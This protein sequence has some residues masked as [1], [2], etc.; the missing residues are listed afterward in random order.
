MNDELQDRNEKMAIRMKR[1]IF[2]LVAMFSGL[3]GWT[4]AIGQLETA[5]NPAESA[6]RFDIDCFPQP[7]RSVDWT[8]AWKSGDV[9]LG[10]KLFQLRCAACHVTDEV[11]P[12][13]QPSV[14]PSLAGVADRLAPE[15][16]AQSIVVPSQNIDAGYQPWKVLTVDGNVVIGHL[17]KDPNADPSSTTL[18]TMNGQRA[19]FAADDIEQFVKSDLSVMPVGLATGPDDVKH[20]TAFLMMLSAQPGAAER[21][22]KL[23]QRWAANDAAER[24]RLIAEGSFAT[25]EFDSGRPQPVPQGSLSLGSGLAMRRGYFRGVPLGEMEGW[26]ISVWFQPHSKIKGDLFGLVLGAAD[27]QAVRV[28]YESGR[29]S[30]S[31][32]GRG[33]NP[34][35]WTLD[36]GNVAVDKWHQLVITR[37]QAAGM[38][39][40]VDGKLSVEHR[41]DQLGYGQSFNQYHFGAAVL[42]QQKDE[43]GQ[44]K[45]QLGDF[46]DGLIDDFTMYDRPLSGDEVS[47]LHDGE[48]IPESMVA[49]NDFE[50]VSHRDLARFVPSADSDADLEEGRQLYEMNCIQCH[51]PDGIQPPKNP[52]ARIFTKHKMENGGDPYSMF[53]TITYGF[54]NMMAAPQLSPEERYKVIHFIREKMIRQQS[55]ELYVEIPETYTNA[56]PHNPRG[57]GAAAARV[58]A[59]AKSGYLRDYGRALIAPVQGTAQNGIRSVNALVVDLGNETTIAYDLGTMKSLGAWQG[60]FL[61]FSNTLHHKLRAAG[62][63]LARF[64]SLPGN[65]DWRWA[66]DGD[67]DTTPP[68]LRPL[69][70]WPE[71][72]VRYRGH[73]PDGDQIIVSYAVQGRGVLESPILENPAL[74]NTQTVHPVIVR[75]MTIQ[76]AANALELVVA[77]G[78]NAKAVIA[79]DQATVTMDP[80]KRPKDS[81]S[82]FF[83]TLQTPSNEASERPHWRISNDGALVLHVPPS[84]ALLNFNLVT[85]GTPKQ[86]DPNTSVTQPADMVDLT[87]RTTGGTRRWGQ[88][89]TMKGKLATDQ[90]QGYVM[91]SVP[92]PL[93]NAYN[94]WMRTASLAFFPDGRLAVATLS[95]D[96]WIV[97]GLD[98]GLKAVTWQRFAA[99]LYEPL[100]MKVVDDVLTVGTRG[101]IVKLH[102]FNND[103]EADF[104]E[105]FFN[106]PEPDPGWHA[107]SFDL[108]VGD[109]GSYYYA[110]VGGFSDWSVPGG[111]VRVAADGKS[112]EVV[113]AGLRVPN[114]IGRLPDGRITFGDNQGTYVPASKIAITHP[115]AFHGA[116]KWPDREGDYD[117]E[118]IVAPIVY[119]PQ[120]LDSS[121]GSQLWV[122]P[123]AR[124]GPL[125]GQFFHT[126]YGR[127]STMVV[128]L[129]EADGITQGAVYPIP[130]KM[131]SGTMRLAKDPADGQLYFSG[132]TGWQAG[133]TREGSIQRMRYT[134][135]D[136]LYLLAAKAR[137]GR[138]ELTFN[139]PLDP[140]LTDFSQWTVQAWNYKWSAQYGSP[141]FKV[142]EPGVEGM[143]VWEIDDVQLSGDGIKAVIKVPDLQPCDTL[144]LDFTVNAKDATSLSSPLYFTIHN[145]PK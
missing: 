89:H 116:G 111:I 123:D 17:I 128:L 80:H 117:P 94:T 145:L 63:P 132:L 61:D 82:A 124:F 57:S 143:D 100:G 129:D 125:G 131:E 106:E 30:V 36:A 27:N 91:D 59:L 144:K 49:F 54:R 6:K 3:G 16:M 104:Y 44:S 28:T 66:W 71:S 120:E 31:G 102:D 115:G 62:Q 118:K 107:Y 98:D 86:A 135:G 2:G 9:R 96:V 25:P 41:R 77:A 35:R 56:M 5:M 37:S 127:A 73:Y 134:G 108:E 90:F 95:G 139:Q 105:A 93:K 7:Y 119:M 24:E 138:L 64:D 32:P 110:R 101:R 141:H 58:E 8:T 67:A 20:L 88:T 55:P 76:P 15:F 83:V 48:M 72:Q 39:V 142:S 84:T 22:D 11:T 109:D 53:R 136:G 114:G 12:G 13:N 19:T 60:G 18:Q 1:M 47:R 45:Q 99:G 51:S 140:A 10:E 29:L 38:N 81:S 33:R 14:G 43:N 126:S 113:G 97:T 34:Q 23:R 21:L 69:T 133:A 50:N 87:Q 103:G 130:M 65:G 40:Y 68:D 42:G 85:T 112:W 75:R 121:A 4:T 122:E 79:G 70:V 92:V 74:E 78:Q 137:Q 26:T 52:A 46:F